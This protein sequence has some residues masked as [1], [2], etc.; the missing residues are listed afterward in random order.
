M[1]EGG[2][3]Y[4]TRDAFATAGRVLAHTP[5]K[6]ARSATGA[7]ATVKP[8]VAGGVTKAAGAAQGAGHFIGSQVN[9]GFVKTKD[10]MLG[11][12]KTHEQAAGPDTSIAAAPAAAS[13]LPI[14]SAPPV[15]A[16]GV[17]RPLHQRP[18]DL[19]SAA[20]SGPA[21]SGSFQAQTPVPPVKAPELPRN[22]SSDPPRLEAH[23]ER[24]RLPYPLGEAPRAERLPAARKSQ[25]RPVENAPLV[26][27][28]GL[29]ESITASPLAETNH[30]LL[31]DG[32]TVYELQADPA[33]D[34]NDY[35]GRRVE[36]VGTRSNEQVGRGQ[37]V[38]CVIRIRALD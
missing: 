16:A 11:K 36:V 26:I 10:F 15:A 33:L 23:P 22:L 4:K 28:D 29:L 32:A 27:A 19:A 38:L 17:E 3:L 5:G 9:H 6:I 12:P 35:L 24:A 25:V 7:Y 1:R 8:K 37:M 20:A 18:T 34:L 13:S 21:S 30:R 14:S 31:K 2:L